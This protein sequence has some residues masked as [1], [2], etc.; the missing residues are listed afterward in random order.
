MKLRLAWNLVFINTKAGAGRVAQWVELLSI[1]QK[2]LG[3]IPS[4][5][6]NRIQ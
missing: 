6:E 5:T 3:S 4:T 2:T 1:M